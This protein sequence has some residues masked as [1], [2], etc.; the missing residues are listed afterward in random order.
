[1]PSREILSGILDAVNGVS[2]WGLAEQLSRNRAAAWS[3]ARLAGATLVPPDFCPQGIARSARAG[4][5]G[6]GRHQH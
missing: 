3:A 5:E 1:M 4:A 6:W 2:G